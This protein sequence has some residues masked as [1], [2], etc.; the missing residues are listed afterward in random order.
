MA[1]PDSTEH[2]EPLN[3]D[4]DQIVKAFLQ[5]NKRTRIHRS[6][7][8]TDVLRQTALNNKEICKWLVHWMQQESTWRNY[9]I[10]GYLKAKNNSTSLITDLRAI[11]PLWSLPDFQ[12]RTSGVE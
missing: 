3:F 11:L 10:A 9:T 8:A 7:I 2:Q 6:G 5:L 4:Q 1:A 12:V